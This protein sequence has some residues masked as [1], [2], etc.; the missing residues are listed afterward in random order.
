MKTAP[1]ALKELGRVYGWR[2]IAGT[3]LFNSERSPQPAVSWTSGKLQNQILK[4]PSF[5]ER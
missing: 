5:V 3:A 2:C 4:R 1:T